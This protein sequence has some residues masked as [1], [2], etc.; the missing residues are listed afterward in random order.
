M[1]SWPTRVPGS[2]AAANETQPT[3]PSAMRL[4]QEMSGFCISRR[5]AQLA[6]GIKLKNLVA[7]SWSFLFHWAHSL[8]SSVS[9]GLW[10]GT[11][12]ARPRT[13]FII[14]PAAGAGRARAR[15]ARLKSELHKQYPQAD[16][17][18][19][20]TPG[21][22]ATLARAAAADFD[23]LVAV[24]GDGTVSEVANGILSSQSSRLILAIVPVGTG[25]DVAATLGIHTLTD[26][27]HSLTSGPARSIDVLQIH[28]HSKGLPVT[29]HALLF[30]GAGII[31]ESLKRTTASCKRF[32]GQRLSYPAGVVRALCTY[33]SPLMRITCGDKG[34]EQ[35][36]LFVGAS[37]TELAGGGMRIAPGARVDDG[38]LNVNLIGAVGRWRALLQL[39]RLCRGQHTKHPSVRYFPADSLQ[40]DATPA[41]DVAA[42]GDIIGETPARIVVRPKALRVLVP[43]MR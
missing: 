16:R 20:T 26:S 41:L 7:A 42:D 28:C 10:L 22:A 18:H 1:D 15:W 3:K 17:A 25:N 11:S 2:S 36:Y 19:T 14:N 39:R 40:I 35:R 21:E 33:L 13:L 6:S 8:S 32:F 34:F 9:A 5:L 37:N 38:L 31:G 12:T 29:Q 24:G 27:L 4:I 30:A 23:L 43:S